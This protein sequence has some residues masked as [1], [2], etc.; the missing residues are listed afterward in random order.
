MVR[1]I[2]ALGLISLAGVLAACGSDPDRSPGD[3]TTSGAGAPTGTGGTGTGSGVATGG[4]TPAPDHWQHGL[5][6][7]VNWGLAE[8]YPDDVG[9]A[10]DEY[11]LGAED[12]ETGT[13]TIP[14]EEDRYASNVTVTS[15]EHY[16]G[17][18]A[19]VHSWDEGENGPTTRF[20]L[21]DEAHL[22]DRPAYFMRMCFKYDQSFHPG[23]PSV[24]VGVKGFGIYYEDGSGNASTCAGM[25]WFNTSCQFVGWG[26][27]Q[28]DEAN[29]GFIW[30]GHMYSY[31]RYPEQAVAAEGEIRIT[32][33][34]DGTEPCR[35]S[36]Y[37][38]PHHYIVFLTWHC[39]ELG[40]YLN[41]PGQHDGE[42]RFWVDGVLR[43]RTTSMRFRDLEEQKPNSM[44]LNLHRT[45]E[46]F[47]QT[48]V[49]WVDNIVLARRYIGPVQLAQ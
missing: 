12:F 47:P 48:M 26:P 25:S 39:Y 1:A 22:D 38:D 15:D 41:T 44:H 40:L 23:D 4:S 31:N 37:P 7:G 8:A 3:A 30:E 33:P 20:V 5:A 27:S 13:V 46:D 29:D 10:A 49:R 42:S 9:I 19:G 6:E 18:Y 43:S 45:T 24:G 35:F 34:P 36:I 32:D 21:G 2:A 28:K 16:T 14:T 17:Q 11:V